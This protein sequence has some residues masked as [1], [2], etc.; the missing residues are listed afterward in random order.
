ME[1]AAE[2]VAF[3]A[4]AWSAAPDDI[5]EGGA[6]GDSE[7]ATDL[8]IVAAADRFGDSITI[9]TPVLVGDDDTVALGESEE[10][11]GNLYRLGII[12]AVRAHWAVE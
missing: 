1:T 11:E 4:E 8:L 7:R 6:A 2:A 3:I 12:D 9:E 10:F 5:Q